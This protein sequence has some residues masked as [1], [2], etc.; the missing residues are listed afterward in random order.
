MKMNIFIFIISI[1]PIFLTAQ[2]RKIKDELRRAS[3]YSE[4]KKMDTY[5]V[6]E[7]YL[8]NAQ[9]YELNMYYWRERV[10]VPNENLRNYWLLN[11][12]E[13]GNT[14]A[15]IHLAY[16]YKIGRVVKKDSVSCRKWLLKAK[17]KKSSQA[18]YYYG[19]NCLDNTFTKKVS[20]SAIQ[21]FLQ[22]ENEDII[23]ASLALSFCY[24]YGLKTKKNDASAY[25]YYN[26]YI[27]L[28][29]TKNDFYSN[30]SFSIDSSIFCPN[31]FYNRELIIQQIEDFIKQ[32]KANSNLVLYIKTNGYSSYVTQQL[33]WDKAN[34]IRTIFI[35]EGIA[36]E[37]ICFQYGGGGNN[38]IVEILLLTKAEDFINVYPPPPVPYFR[39]YFMV[40]CDLD[41]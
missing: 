9:R 32:L 22:A 5:H 41:N 28:N 29:K 6:Y 24:K 33:S 40:E 21:Y 18:L 7:K 27:K 15:Q 37:R 13:D 3:K 8:T 30:Y 19:L 26:K 11:S 14:C 36:S 2:P 20:D 34:E 39:K 4:S 16:S 17:A 1:I 38:S 12:A 35:D 10:A 25:N 23:D 31:G